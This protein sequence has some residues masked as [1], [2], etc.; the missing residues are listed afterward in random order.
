[1][2][3]IIILILFVSS[4]NAQEYVKIEGKYYL[5]EVK[6]DVYDEMFVEWAKDFEKRN[7]MRA[8]KI[9]PLELGKDIFNWIKKNRFTQRERAIFN[10]GVKAI[11]RDLDFELLEPIEK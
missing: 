6:E 2:R 4:L 7:E 3:I 1:M 10:Y 5:K 9:N 8:N 11:N